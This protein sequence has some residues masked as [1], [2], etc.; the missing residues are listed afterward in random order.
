M[1]IKFGDKTK[2]KIVKDSSDDLNK[3]KDT[4][5]LDDEESEDRRIPILKSYKKITQKN[6][7]TNKKT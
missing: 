1:F 6:S 2:S 7:Q 5:Y 3:D 4:V